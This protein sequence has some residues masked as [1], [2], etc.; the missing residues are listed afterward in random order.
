MSSIKK[1]LDH[2]NRFYDT[3]EDIEECTKGVCFYCNNDAEVS[4]EPVQVPV[5]ILTSRIPICH[6]CISK[7][8]G[9]YNCR[10][11]LSKH[12]KW[13]KF[14]SREELQWTAEDLYDYCH[15]KQRYRG[16]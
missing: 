15:N 11:R 3:D 4:S 12:K 9:C 10:N 14:Y 16:I 6:N 7:H 8:I 1:N 13:R 2:L 5:G